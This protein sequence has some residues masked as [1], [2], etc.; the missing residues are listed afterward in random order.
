[1]PVIQADMD[2]AG[3]H[4]DEAWSVLKGGKAVASRA[5]H[6]R[7]VEPLPSASDATRRTAWRVLLNG[8]EVSWVQREFAEPG[9]RLRF[10]QVTGD[11]EELSGSW[12]VTEVPGGS[13]VSLTVSFH[14]GV[15][16]LAPL[17]DPIW[18]QSFQAHADALLRALTATLREERP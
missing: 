8:S 7:A 16:G 15:D 11:L 10:E 2:L 18:S 3:V 14:L 4:P 6:V 13:R 5:G 17:L 9:P 12:S 1:M